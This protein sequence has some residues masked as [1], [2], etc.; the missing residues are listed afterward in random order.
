[1]VVC[2]CGDPWLQGK[3]VAPAGFFCWR[4]SL[5][6]VEEGPAVGS[7]HVVDTGP[8]SAAVALPTCPGTTI[9]LQV[10]IWAEVQAQVGFGSEAGLG[11]ERALGGPFLL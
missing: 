3:V 9:E 5:F 11:S 10:C 1:M 8:E 4:R 7:A 6:S 2:L